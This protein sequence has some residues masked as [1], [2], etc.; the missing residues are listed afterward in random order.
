[1][2]RLHIHL[3]VKDIA[4]S[5][6]FYEALFGQAPTIAKSDYA[7]WLLD[8]PQAHIAISTHGGEPG[9]DH[10]GIAMDGAGLQ[11]YRQR[12]DGLKAPLL[13]EEETVCCYAKSNKIWARD[14]QGALWELFDSYDQAADYGAEPDRSLRDLPSP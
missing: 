14:P 10:V 13:E 12:L 5:T 4:E 6:A 3:K 11:A 1:M 2:K 9:L 8:D 7:K